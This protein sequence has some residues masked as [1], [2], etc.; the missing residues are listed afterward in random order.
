MQQKALGIIISEDGY[1][2]TNNHIIDS[3]DSSYFYEVSDAKS[4]KVSLY[5]D[6]TKYDAEIIGMDAETDLAVIKINKEGLIAAKLGN[7]D[8][9]KIG[10]FAIAIGNPLGMQSS[11]TAGIISAVNRNVEAEDGTEYVAI[12]TDAAINSRK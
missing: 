11:V 6:E 4:V 9:V 12:Q 5:N 3:R 7:S 2:L 10:E 8:E 1:I